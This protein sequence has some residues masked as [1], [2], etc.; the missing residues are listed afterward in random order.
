MQQLLPVEPAHIPT[1]RERGI[2]FRTRCRRQFWASFCRGLWRWKSIMPFWK[3]IA[4]EQ[5]A[6]MVA[7]RNATD[8][9]NDLISD[10]DPDV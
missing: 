3:S 9:A 8:N 5:S 10:L 6:R 1:G 4:S 2:Y 7:M